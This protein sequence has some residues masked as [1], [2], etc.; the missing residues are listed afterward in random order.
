MGQWDSVDR[1]PD[2]EDGYKLLLGRLFLAVK[3][4]DETSFEVA[5]LDARTQVSE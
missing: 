3:T 1:Q 4:R 5:L 2:P